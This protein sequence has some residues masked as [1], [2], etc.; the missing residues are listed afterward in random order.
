MSDDEVTA[1][2]KKLLGPER[3]SITNLDVGV[4]ITRVTDELP[5]ITEIERVRR[6]LTSPGRAGHHPA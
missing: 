4:A 2:A 3:R 5:S 1:I 6:R